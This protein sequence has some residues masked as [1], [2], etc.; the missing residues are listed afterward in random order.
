MAIDSIPV[1][2]ARVT[3]IV[4]AHK[5]IQQTIHT[6]RRIKECTPPP[7]EIIV[8]VD[9]NQ[10]ECRD[11]LATLFSDIKILFSTENIGPGGSRNKLI[12]TAGNE[13]VA[14]FDDD[15]HPID[16]DYFS[17]VEE[18]FRKI[19]GASIIYGKVFNKHDP[20]TDR[21][22]EAKWAS[23]F[24]GGACIYRRAHFV[25]T[26]GY[27]PVPIAYGM[28]EVDISLRL[29]STGRRILYCAALRVFHDSDLT[30]HERAAITS[31]SLKNIALLTWLRYPIWH[32][33]R[34][35]F[36]YL[37][38]IRW[39]V[40]NG[41]LRGVLRGLIMTPV[42][43]ARYTGFRRVVS[44]KDINDYLALRANPAPVW[45]PRDGRSS[46]NQIPSPASR[47]A[48]VTAMVTAHKRIQQAIDTISRIQQCSP[49]PAEIIIHVD[50]NQTVC[51]DAITETYPDLRV[52]FSSVAIGPGGGR[53]KLIEAASNELVASFDDDSYPID[54]DYF[55]RASDLAA[56]L[57]D[58]AVIGNTIF[59]LNEQVKDTADKHWWSPHF[60]GAGAICRRSLFL[61]TSGYVPLPLA[62]GMEEVDLSLRLWAEN[63]P[64]LMTAA[65]RVFHNTDLKRHADPRVTAASIANVALLV[66]LRYPLR[67][68]PWGLAQIANRVRWVV[69]NGRVKG[70]LTG[71]VSIPAHV[72]KH[73]KHRKVLPAKAILACR[74]MR[75]RSPADGVPLA[76]LPSAAPVIF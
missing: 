53:N 41:R 72:W 34:G 27:V 48:P 68:W 23:D 52:Y 55:E 33:F 75:S 32:W 8:H 73:W 47:A 37:N 65:L 18:L 14:S 64:I 28:E 21:N 40:F 66:A 5:R 1:P 12:A 69:V 36:Q 17:V 74:A 30:H 42:Q 62:Y 25:E 19:P 29:L 38:R 4:T 10:N 57:P 44:V 76:E 45:I 22:Y 26:D 24:C 9:G 56:R 13:L 49:P 71:L 16:L 7:A 3:A 67:L 43:L 50:D 15:S 35:L 2:S 46:Q 20:V 58:A 11:I 6:I 31:A 60:C 39:L 51:R 61:Q 63:H 59:H 70:C 54:Q